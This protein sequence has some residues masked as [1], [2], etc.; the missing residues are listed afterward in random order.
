MKIKTKN[1]KVSIIIPLF[2]PDK[3]VFD[4]VMKVLK[5]QTLKAEI[6]LED[7]GLP[8]HIAIN[9]GIK[10]AKGDIIVT[11]D[12]D[13][14]PS[15][16][17]WLE[18]LVKPLIENEHIVATASA[19]EYPYELWKTLDI[20]NRALTIKE[21][22]EIFF[23]MDERGCAYKKKVLEKVGF[24]NESR[25]TILG[26]ID[27]YFK[28]KKEGNIAYPKKSKIYHFHPVSGFKKIRK[29][30]DYARGVGLSFLVYG[31]KDPVWWR[32][33]LKI[34]PFFGSFFTW[35]GFP[36]K[37]APLLFLIY[38]LLS[39]LLYVVF[40]AGIFDGILRGDK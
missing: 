12:Q 32:R 16:N 19:Y 24:F 30:Y 35:I 17:I 6:I 7:E 20:V 26:D 15:S 36:I 10:K 33:V 25:K 29:E 37:R 5:Q 40:I 14:I 38:V 23:V 39:P 9:K 2:K 11:L 3:K 18:E 21:Q 22:R 34:I 8:E 1:P 28:L 13:C 27:L 4:R 31:F